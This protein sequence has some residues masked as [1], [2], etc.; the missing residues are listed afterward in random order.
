MT[1]NNII[2][3]FGEVK[4]KIIEAGVFVD[5]QTGEQVPYDDSIKIWISGFEKKISPYGLACLVRATQDDA[6]KKVLKER[7]DKQLTSMRSASG[8]FD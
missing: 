8:I 2:L 6:V 1:E 4:L 7:L 3:D 5:E